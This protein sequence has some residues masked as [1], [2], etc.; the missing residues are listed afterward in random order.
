MVALVAFIELYESDLPSSDDRREMD[1]RVL[2]LDPEQVR[3]V[4]L[5]WAANHVLLQSD[6]ETEGASQWTLVD[7]FG[8]PADDIEVERLIDSLTE[9]ER[10]RTL[11]GVKRSETGLDPPRLTATLSTAETSER[12]E[13]GAEVPASDSM[14]VRVAGRDQ[15]YVVDDLLWSD[16]TREPGQWRRRTVFTLERNDI[17]RLRL[18]G[19]LTEVEIH[20]RE[21]EFWVERPFADRADSQ[22]VDDLLA[23]VV[24]LRVDRFIDEATDEPRLAAMG[25]SPDESRLEIEV[26]DR[27]APL[28]LVWGKAV[29]GDPDRHFAATEDL[30]F[31]TGSG[32]GRF[33][34]LQPAE[35]RSREVISL[36]PFEI[37]AFEAVEKG[38]EPVSLTRSGADWIRGDT[39]VSFPSVSDFLYQ[40]SGLRAI[41]FMEVGP[42]EAT[43]P[44]LSEPRLELTMKGPDGEQH[45]AFGEPRNGQVRV[46]ARDRKI[47]L[48]VGEDAFTE[49]LGKLA[50]VR[51]AESVEGPETEQ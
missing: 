45:V 46:E 6:A 19:R 13:I 2:R 15:L 11:S 3:A 32:I 44:D 48:V 16:L 39:T 24:S 43:R 21:G 41:D 23:G 42:G 33:F 29:E 35:W 7:P 34:D 38:L 5:E 20:D 50:A 1:R 37:D 26:Q 8:A 25:L 49:L 47:G 12:L 31:E 18:R 4:E 40:V 27:P 14:I 36:E 22:K 9:L 28:S 17:E 30:V 10:R 51:A